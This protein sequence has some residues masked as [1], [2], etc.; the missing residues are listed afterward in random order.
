[1]ISR[2]F[3]FLIALHF[4]LYVFLTVI[5]LMTTFVLNDEELS[6]TLQYIFSVVPSFSFGYGMYNVFINLK[7]LETW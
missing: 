4:I 5:T 1:M 2:G 3:V 7:R 6:K